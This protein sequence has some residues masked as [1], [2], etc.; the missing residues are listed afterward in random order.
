MRVAIVH[1]WLVTEGGAEKV[2][3]EL[4]ELFPQADIYTI[5]DFLNEAQRTK[6][7]RGKRSHT[8]FIQRL[9]LARTHFRYYLPLMPKAIRSFDLSH[10]D[11]VISSS[12]AFAKGVQ[13]RRH[14]CYCHTPIRY[15]WDLFE[16][17]TAPLPPIKREL[18]RWSLNQ[19]R[20]WDRKYLP[21]YFIAN[22]T[23]VAYR[24]RRIYGRESTIIYPPVDTDRFR[25][26]EK[27]ENYYFTL[28]RLVP[29]KK[30][31]LLVETFNKMPNRHL[32]VAGTGEELEAIRAIAGPNVEV[33]GYVED[34]VAVELMQRAKAFIYGGYEDFGIVMAEALACGTPVIAYGKGGALDI[35]DR[36]SGVLFG[37]QS[38]EAVERGIREFE[39]RSFNPRSIRERALIFRRERFLQEFQKVVDGAL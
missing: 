7:L 31:R 20:R 12:W 10:Y 8:S 21:D 15:A 17:Y 5:V 34:S 33:L 22:S 37:E 35:V 4:L 11:L 25:L 2:L 1:D 26:W 24:I 27:K 36:E 28:S 32:I 18:V 30:T 6:I 29:Y 14:I 39:G 13:G 16:E 9:P 38:I 19:I 23:E 3:R